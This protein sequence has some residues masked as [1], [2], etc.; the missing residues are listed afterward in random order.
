[1]CCL[2]CCILV[3]FIIDHDYHKFSWI[4]IIGQ[5]KNW[6]IKF[7]PK[8]FDPKEFFVQFGPK[9]ILYPRFLVQNNFGSN[10]F[11][12]QNILGHKKSEK[13][14]HQ[15]KYG[16]KHFLMSGPKRLAPETCSVQNIF[17]KFGPKN[18]GSTK[19]FAQKSLIPTKVWSKKECWSEK[20]RPPK[21]WDK[22]IGSKNVSNNWDVPDM[23]K[24]CQDKCCLD[25]C[26]RD[27]WHLLRMVP[28][29]YL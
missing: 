6:L 22:T 3:V 1:M 16:S 10:K 15:Q 27:D 4:E 25:K 29:T 24:C 14:C 2:C 28:G 26:H 5:E 20:L 13:N 23:G 8:V 21:N 9:N 11:W 19:N 18:F 12:V 7:V 17:V